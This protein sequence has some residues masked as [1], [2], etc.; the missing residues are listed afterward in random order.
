MLACFRASCYASL[1]PFFEA[2][3]R[4]VLARWGALA[5][6]VSD[7]P[8]LLLAFVSQESAGDPNASRQEPQIGDESRGLGQILRGTLE[9]MQAERRVPTE[10][11]Y[12]DLWDPRANLVVASA[13]VTRQ[14]TRYAG[15]LTK[16]VSSYNQ[17]INLR[18]DSERLRPPT[19]PAY[20]A[21]VLAYYRWFLDHWHADLG[22]PPPTETG[23]P[24]EEPGAPPAVAG[25]NGAGATTVP[26][27]LVLV[28]LLAAA[29]FTR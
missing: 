6:E 23:P 21:S 18:P 29:R 1:M 7:N 17:G 3:A 27:I 4:A 19:N 5:A 8:M 10:I 24:G 16:A 15:D 12:E 9:Q 11:S 22:A 26:V 2:T 13:I 14:V 28:A 25:L 20:V